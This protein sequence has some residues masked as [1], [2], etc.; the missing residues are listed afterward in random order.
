MRL[1]SYPGLAVSIQR[2]RDEHSRTVLPGRINRQRAAVGLGHQSRQVQAQAGAPRV[3]GSGTVTAEKGLSERLGLLRVQPRPVILHRNCQTVCVCGN[4][5]FNRSLRPVGVAQRTG[6]QVFQK[7]RQPNAVSLQGGVA[8]DLHGDLLAVPS[9]IIGQHGLDQLADGHLG[10]G[11]GA[12]PVV[13]PFGFQQ[14]DKNLKY[15]QNLAGRRLAI[16]VLLSTS[17]PR[18][19]NA[20]PSVVAAVADASPGSYQEVNVSGGAR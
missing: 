11:Q 19:Q 20:L 2:Q 18:I 7:Q 13:Q 12:V 6:N 9:K 8:L 10:A 17:W 5:N 4:T 1:Q 16:V 15:Q 3:T 14:G